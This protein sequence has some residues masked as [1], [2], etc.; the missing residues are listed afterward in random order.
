MKQRT[1]QTPLR[2]VASWRLGLVGL[3]W[4]CSG[5]LG[6]AQDYFD[7]NQNLFMPRVLNQPLS[8]GED[9][10][11]PRPHRIR[12][13]GISPGFLSDP[14]GLDQ[15]DFNPG[16]PGVPLVNPGP[17][18][19]D[20]GP[21]WVSLSVG[22]DN[23]YFETRRHGDPGGVGYYRLST[24]VQVVDSQTTGW[25]VGFQAFT[26]AGLQNAGLANGPTTVCPNVGFFHL[27][28]SDGTAIQ[29]FVG[30]RV[31]LDSRLDGQ[32]RER[33]QYGMALQQP[34]WT[35]LA[36]GGGTTYVYLEAQGRYRDP[37]PGSITPPALWQFLPG[38]SWRGSNNVWMS[39]GIVLPIG[40]ARDTQPG[41]LQ[42][43]C[44]F[45]F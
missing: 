15:D 19:S 8:L 13:L 41:H 32:I 33:F 7:G 24:Q 22:N 6:R 43:S 39:S 36:S 35:D 3:V 10:T 14:L 28:G 23:P 17:S 29:G 9:V 4:L 11:P 1:S 44:S 42:I 27:L 26:P 37:L 12:V 18:L 30:N 5:A 20:S 25:T 21:D 2:F 34:I 31:F 40:P 16:N 45:Q 38:L